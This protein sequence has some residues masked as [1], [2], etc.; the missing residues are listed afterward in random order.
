MIN[1]IKN[2]A[3][4]KLFYLYLWSLIPREEHLHDLK[5]IF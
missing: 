2:V 1:D 4:K 5:K 3:M